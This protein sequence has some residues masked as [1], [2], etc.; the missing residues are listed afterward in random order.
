MAENCHSILFLFWKPLVFVTAESCH[1]IPSYLA[2]SH[3]RCRLVP[4]CRCTVFGGCR[5]FLSFSNM[6]DHNTAW[7]KYKNRMKQNHSQK[8]KA[9][10][11][12]ARKIHKSGNLTVQRLSSQVSG[13]AQ[14]FSQIG[15]WEFVPFEDDDMT[16]ANIKQACE[17]HFLPVIGKNMSCDVLAGEQGPSCSMLEHIPNLK[18]IHIRFIQHNADTEQNHMERPDADAMFA[19]PEIPTR[20]RENHDKFPRHCLDLWRPQWFLASK[21]YQGIPQE[22]LGFRYDEAGKGHSKESHHYNRAALFWPW[23]DG[24]VCHSVDCWV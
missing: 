20:N 22:P 11:G 10:V 6:G 12:V 5:C 1:S 13:K 23:S 7:L 9:D 15:A 16:L 3:V 19:T 8:K 21:A 17:K 4:S 2:G 24:M 14:K 18:L